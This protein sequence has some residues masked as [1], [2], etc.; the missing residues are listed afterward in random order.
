MTWILPR[1]LHTLA[2]AL[3]TAALIS[4]LNEQSQIFA[5]SLLARSKLTPARTWSLKWKRESW[6]RHLSGRILKPSLGEHFVT[7]WTSYLEVIP[8]SH[9]AQPASGSAP[10]IHATS[11]PTSQMELESCSPGFVFS[12][13]SKD[14]SALDSEQSLK[15]WEA[16]VMKQ[17]GE[18]SQ[19]VKLAHPTS[20]SGCSSWP[21][22]TARDHRDTPGMSFYSTN[23]DGSR[24]VRTDL[25]PTRVYWELAGR[26]APTNP[27]TDGNRPES[28]ATPQSRDFRS[29]DAERFTNPDRSKNLN[30]QIKSW[31]TPEALNSTGYQNQANG[32]RVLR[33]GSQV[34][35]GKLNPRWVETLMGLPVGWTMP[36][37]TSP[38]TIAPTNSASSETELSPPPQP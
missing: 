14:T 19:R 6:T 9:S 37:C 24:R 27:S 10:T 33:L 23:P 4:D 3:D 21:T 13:T 38:V 12:K 15:N 34:T 32:A 29:G 30:D 16:S 7:A 28:W 31:A 36:S 18:Y 2:S 22:A 17:R 8:A 1:Q 11:G 26:P 20:A 5:Q 35:G 25:L